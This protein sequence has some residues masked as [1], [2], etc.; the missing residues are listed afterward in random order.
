MADRNRTLVLLALFVGR[1]VLSLPRQRRRVASA[2]A[3]AYGYDKVELG[4]LSS[5][6][7]LAY[8]VGK[9]LSDRSA[10]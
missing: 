9:L 4:R 3:R 1:V 2:L 10:T 8:A 7:L 5:M 6:A